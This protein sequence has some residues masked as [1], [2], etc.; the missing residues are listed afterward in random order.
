MR[1]ILASLAAALLV[2]QPAPATLPPWTPGTLDIHQIVTARGNAA[3]IRYPDGTSLL[4][5]AG[6]QGTS[7]EMN[8]QPD[9]SRPAADAIT[10]YLQHALGV[11]RPHLD[12]ALFTHFHPDHVGALSALLPHLQVD[13]IVDRGYDYLAPPANDEVFRT[14]RALIDGKV[15]DRSSRH[16]A[17]RAGAREVIAAKKP[18]DAFEARIISANDH[19][20]TGEGDQT[21]Q[22][23]PALAGLAAEDRPTENMCSVTLRLTYG[24]FDFFAGGD[25]P[26]Y[27]VPGAPAWHDLESDVARAIGETDVHVVNHHGS[28]EEENPFW[29]RTLRSQVMIVPAWSPT[30]PSPDV[31]KRMLSTRVY[32]DPRDIFITLFRPPTQATTGPRA[33]QVASD[34]GHVV[35]RVEPGGAHFSVFVL[36]DQ[37]PNLKV[38][39]LKG[40]YTSGR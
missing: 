31:L 12:Y 26:G 40:P 19:V 10:A 35:V 6:D 32:P 14:Y 23:F 22:R 34:R 20:W 9:R 17:A 11:E 25:Q 38:R 30:H 21:K 7:D 8:G 15:A 36:D 27:P 16:V 4:V 28:I 18:I 5:D 2:G 29:L 33:K 3:F 39:L 1:T 24:A 13:T 37:D